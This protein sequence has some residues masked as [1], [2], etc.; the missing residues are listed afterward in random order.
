MW[1]IIVHKSSKINGCLCSAPVPLEQ[2]LHPL[3]QTTA[4]A[5]IYDLLCSEGAGNGNTEGW[6]GVLS[7]WL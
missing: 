2:G 6:E 5:I 7:V 1:I 3:S 4:T